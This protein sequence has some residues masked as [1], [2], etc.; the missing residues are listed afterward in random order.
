MAPLQALTLT[1]LRLVRFIRLEHQGLAAAPAE[2][3]APQKLAGSQI[4]QGCPFSQVPGSAGLACTKHIPWAPDKPTPRLFLLPQT[5]QSPVWGR[6][7]PVTPKGR[8][9]AQA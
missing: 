4:P 9:M 1:L 8:L 2:G 6:H 5:Q 3:C 7:K